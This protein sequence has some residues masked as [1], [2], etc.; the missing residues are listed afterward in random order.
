MLRKVLQQL[1]TYSRQ[2]VIEIQPT[3]PART[4]FNMRFITLTSDPASSKL[5]PDI[6]SSAYLN[7]VVA[8]TSQPASLELE[9]DV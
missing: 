8:L 1:N 7:P 4:N 6:G 9:P 5:K 2:Q 3:K